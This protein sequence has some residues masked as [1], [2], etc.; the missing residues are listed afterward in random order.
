MERTSARGWLVS[1]LALIAAGV[2][3]LAPASSSAYDPIV[4]AQNFS[5][6][7]ERTTQEVAT[8]EFLARIEQQNVQ[9]AIDFPLLLAGDPE[10]NPLGNICAQRK[11]ECAGDVRFYDWVDEG[12]GLRTPVLFTARSGA[13]I[14]GN[15]WRTRE[16][17]NERPAIVITTGSVQAPET[18]Y[19]GIAAALAKR[20]YVVLTYD[21]QGQG[22]SDTFGEGVD[23][24]EG[25]PSQAGQPFYDGT[26]DA[27]NFMLSTPGEPY[28]DVMESS[29]G[30]ANA[31]TPTSHVAKQ[32]RREGE[33]DPVSGHR[34]AEPFN[35]FWDY[36]DADRIGIAGHSLGASAVSYIGQRDPRVKAIAAWDNLRTSDS[37]GSECPARPGTRTGVPITKP[38][39]GFSNDYGIAQSPYFSD[40][41]PQGPND[42][43]ADFKAQGVDSMQIN[44]RGGTHFEYSFIP[45]LTANQPL[46]NATLRGMHLSVWYTAAW[47][48]KYVKCPGAPDPAACEARADAALL[49]DRWRDDAA[50]EA[51][52][53][54]IP[55]D[56]NMFSFYLRSRFDFTL[57]DG[58]AAVCEDMRTGCP[59]M[60]PDGDPD[61]PGSYSYVE[62]GNSP[63][64]AVP[65]SPTFTDTDPDSPADDTTPLIKGTAPA[66]STVDIYD[67]ASCSGSPVATGTAAAFASPGLEATVPTDSTTGFWGTATDGSATPSACSTSTISYTHQTPTSEPDTQIDSGPAGVSNDNDPEFTF[68]SPGTPAATFECRLDPAGP[69]GWTACVSPQAYTDLADGEH[70]FEVR[71]VD[72]G[73]PDPTPASSTFS[74]DATA[75]AAPVLTSTDPGSPAN[76]NSPEVIGE[77]EPAA[78]VQLYATA[79][80]SG[81]AA[82]ATAA[83][84][85]D[86]GLTQAVADDSQTSFSATATDGAGNTSAC[87]AAITYV[88]DSTA[89]DTTIDGGPGGATASGRAGFAFS[90]PDEDAE[91]YECRLVA[92]G[93]GGNGGWGAC[94]SPIAYRDLARGDYAFE[95][96]AID[97][98]ANTD[99]TP[100]RAEFTVAPA[101]PPPTGGCTQTI[102][103]TNGP[104]DISGTAASD[105]IRGR[106]GD[107]KVNAIGGDD[108]VNGG[109]GDDRLIGGSGEDELRGKAG[110]DRLSGGNGRD[111]LGGGTG[112]DRIDAQGGGKDFVTCGPGKDR[113]FVDAA[114]E[115]GKGC[116][117]VAVGIP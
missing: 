87:S 86:P 82:T 8:P 79:D 83:E 115:V 108:C 45:G 29:C 43:F 20:G 105:R 92:A 7:L 27:L 48:D 78:L 6:I 38:S 107:D 98:A 15:V 75:P 36:V 96:R 30:N 19:W 64:G 73:V 57:A 13:V 91:R 63:D 99:A 101:E 58:N 18:L 35:P 117:K 95:A 22:R 69:G 90:S 24:Q 93:D 72:A 4:E 109:D 62:E 17:P 104:D 31:D 54:T 39:I 81:A 94:T 11:N 23:S 47:M 51:I 59:N 44:I 12:Y 9:D 110:N 70:T 74:I 10:R 80:C 100:A 14:S 65:S 67:N 55:P 26:E 49:T 2:G 1:S 112:N 76:E 89:P 21:V 41:D 60:N 28:A 111:R 68:S 77:A 71:A 116:D 53:P 37:G 66:G 42:A 114:D 85:A 3:L 25:F 56:P 50:N 88:E 5:K 40:P 34:L 46:G 102:R 97:G 33:T 61:Y 52:D 113:A 106:G 84:L 32:E 16:G 103:G